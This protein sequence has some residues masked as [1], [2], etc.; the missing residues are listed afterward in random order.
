MEF[1]VA[2]ALWG[3][4]YINIH[5][6]GLSPLQNAEKESLGLYGPRLKP[7]RTKILCYKV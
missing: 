2:S 6:I 7:G 3:T 1:T 4:N 5:R